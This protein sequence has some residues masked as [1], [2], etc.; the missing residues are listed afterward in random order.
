M[1]WL[2]ALLEILHVDRKQ[3]ELELRSKMLLNKQV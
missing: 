3:R 2:N 1:E